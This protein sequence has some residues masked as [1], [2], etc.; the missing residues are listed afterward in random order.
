MKGYVAEMRKLAERR[1]CLFVDL[2][3]LTEDFL[4][5]MNDDQCHFN[6]VGHRV[7]SQAAFNTIAAN[8]SF[9]GRKSIRQARD[10]GLDVTN[11]GGTSSTSRMV[12]HWLHR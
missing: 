12:H 9:V 3:A 6:D 8:C 4:W 11:T 1:E 10:A 7:I 5:L 2:Y